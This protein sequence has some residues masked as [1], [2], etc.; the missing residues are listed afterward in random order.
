MSEVSNDSHR[1]ISYHVRS[2]ATKHQSPVMFGEQ[3]QTLEDVGPGI[4]G[5]PMLHQHVLDMC[6]LSA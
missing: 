1:G 3:L 5:G 6:G 2:E 4:Q